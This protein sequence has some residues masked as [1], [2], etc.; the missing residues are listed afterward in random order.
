MADKL[1][2]NVRKIIVLSS[3]VS[4]MYNF[5]YARILRCVLY[6]ICDA[7]YANSI[8]IIRLYN[9]PAKWVKNLFGMLEGTSSTFVLPESIYRTQ[10]HVNCVFSTISRICA[11]SFIIYLSSLVVILQIITSTVKLQLWTYRIR[12]ENPLKGLNLIS[13]TKLP[14]PVLFRDRK[15]PLQLPFWI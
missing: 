7:S 1:Q 14:V 11:L 15:S 13:Y 3:I 6:I 8:C 4:L 10:A 9:V 2:T 12:D 5:V